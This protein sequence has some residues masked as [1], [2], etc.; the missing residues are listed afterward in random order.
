LKFISIAI[1]LT[2]HWLTLLKIQTKWEYS[3]AP[4]CR[5]VWHCL[6]AKADTR[7]IWP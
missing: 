6:P 2:N 4:N 3:N 1:L 5:E 7:K